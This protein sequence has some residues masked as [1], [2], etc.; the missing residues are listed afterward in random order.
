[1]FLPGIQLELCA[2]PC[3]RIIEGFSHFVTSMTAPIAF[4][5]SDCRVGL[6]PTEKRRLAWRIQN[7]H[8]RQ[9]LPIINFLNVSNNDQ[10]FGNRKSMLVL[11]PFRIRFHR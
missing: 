1:M 5:W 9:S 4:G 10:Y 7:R 3:G 8:G 11:S 6:A 2:Q